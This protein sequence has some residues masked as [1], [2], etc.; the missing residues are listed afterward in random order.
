MV[1]KADDLRLR[2][3]LIEYLGDEATNALLERLPLTPVANFATKDDIAALRG[4]MLDE[5]GKLRTEFGTLAGT[6]AQLEGRFEG[7]FGELEGRFEGRF[8]RVEGALGELEGK[9]GQLEGKFGQLQGAFGELRAEVSDLRVD[10]SDRLRVHTWAVTG[11]FA[12]GLGIAIAVSGL[13]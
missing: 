7:R 9:F 11:L 8:G 4:E 10:I 5:F 3:L 13:G 12:S 1:S 2:E 6:V